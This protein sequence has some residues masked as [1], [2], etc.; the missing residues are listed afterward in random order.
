MQESFEIV[1]ADDPFTLFSVWFAEATTLEPADPNAMVLATT[2]SDGQPTAR[3]MLMKSYDRDGFVFYTNQESRKSHQLRANDKVGLCFYWKS[4]YRQVHIEGTVSPVS[5]AESD[6]YF[7]SR[8]RQSQIGA[9][10]SQQSRPLSSR[11]ELEDRI[12]SLTA[13]YEGKVIPRPPHW[14]GYRVTPH[15]IEFWRGHEFRLHDRVVYARATP[16]EKW[17]TQ[18]IYP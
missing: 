9:W 1:V 16:Q 17:T 15:R 12:Q 4:L 7:A 3:A 8:P 2:G 14:G 6:E 5:P 11:K 18:R 10:A 13:Q